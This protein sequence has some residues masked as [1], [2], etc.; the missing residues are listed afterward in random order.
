MDLEL[1][2]KHRLIF[3][4]CHICSGLNESEQEIDRCT[5]CKKSFMPLNYFGKIH[6][7]NSDEFKKLFAYSHELHEEDLIKGIYA[8]W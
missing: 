7:Q 1:E 2:N 6:A 3:K 5:K 8:L 4:V